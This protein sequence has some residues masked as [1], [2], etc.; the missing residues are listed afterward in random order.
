MTMEFR[1][2]IAVPG[3]PVDDE[4]TWEPFIERLERELDGLGPVIGWVDGHAEVV[5][6]TTA[7][8][9]SAAATEL[10]AA[11]AGQMRAAGLPGYPTSVQLEVVPADDLAF[12]DA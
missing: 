2:F 4:S 8:D 3:L 7:D 11:V 12:S 5:V 1:A 9:E 6:S 10:Y